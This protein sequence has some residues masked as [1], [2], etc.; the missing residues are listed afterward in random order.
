VNSITR[1]PLRMRH[2]IRRRLVQI[3]RVEQLS[4]GMRRIVLGGDELDGFTSAAADDHVKL[5]FP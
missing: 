2:E 3:V 4:P 1:T 5:F